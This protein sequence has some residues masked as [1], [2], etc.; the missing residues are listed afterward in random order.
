LNGCKILSHTNLLLLFWHIN[1]ALITNSGRP[2]FAA[3]TAATTAEGAYPQVA[4]ADSDKPVGEVPAVGNYSRIMS[5]SGD[6]VG[7]EF[8][9]MDKLT[10]ADA[11]KTVW[12]RARV[13]NVR[14]KVRAV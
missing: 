12:V 4:Y 10:A 11:G 5:A 1:T 2:R 14:A 8:A 9:Q 13:H 3:A 6:K 7:R